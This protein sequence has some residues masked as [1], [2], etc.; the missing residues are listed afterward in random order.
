MIGGDDWEIG[1]LAE[2]RSSIVAAIMISCFSTGAVL[3]LLG[4]YKGGSLISFV[5]FPVQCGFLAGCGFKIVKTGVGFMI[6]V[7][8]L[9]KGKAGW[10][11]LTNFLPVAIMGFFIIWV[12][13]N[14]RRSKY[15]HWTLS[16]LL[17][18]QDSLLRL[19]VNHRHLLRGQPRFEPGD[20]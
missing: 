8:Y 3:Y 19:I 7:K 18:A 2:A 6:S 14:F 20:T 11:M 4:K 15:R 12:E 1:C 10:A 17:S 9:L 13:G 5:P 16:L